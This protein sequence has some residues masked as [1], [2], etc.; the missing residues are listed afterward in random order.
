M[1]TNR[2]Y[3]ADHEKAAEYD[4]DARDVR[5]L[6]SVMS[7]LDEQDPRIAG[8]DGRFLVI[9]A[10]GKEYEV[11]TN[12]RTCTCPDFEHNLPIENPDGSVRHSCKHIARC[13]YEAGQ[14]PIPSWIDRDALDDQIGVHVSTTP[15]MAPGAVATDGGDADDDDRPADCCCVEPEDHPTDGGLPCFPC[16][17]AGHR[18]PAGA[19]GAD[20]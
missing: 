11:D 4:L 14:R 7:V 15:R 2:N 12:E 9:S 19:R 13:T 8:R 3:A 1:T 17:N 6:T 10:S 5:A 16:W 20:R 18:S